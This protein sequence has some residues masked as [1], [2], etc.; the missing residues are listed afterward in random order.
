VEDDV[1]YL[2]LVWN[3]SKRDALSLCERLP[4]HRAPCQV[5]SPHAFAQLAPA[6]EG[7]VDSTAEAAPPQNEGSQ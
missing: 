1:G 4:G 3:M 2:A 7:V 5:M 6:V